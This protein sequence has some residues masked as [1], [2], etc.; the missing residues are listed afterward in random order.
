MRALGPGAGSQAAI[1][2]TLGEFIV[3]RLCGRVDV[4]G[5]EKVVQRCS[6]HSEGLNISCLE[7]GTGRMPVFDSGSRE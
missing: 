3:R 5:G 1:W 2:V 4:S 7:V 6:R